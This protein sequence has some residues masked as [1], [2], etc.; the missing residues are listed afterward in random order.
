[1]Q[2][3]SKF[4][5][6]SFFFCYIYIYINKY[7]KKFFHLNLETIKKLILFNIVYFLCDIYICISFLLYN[8][9]GLKT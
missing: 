2:K 1:M 3:Y 6:V 5:I 8:I 7:Y 4:Y 9:Y